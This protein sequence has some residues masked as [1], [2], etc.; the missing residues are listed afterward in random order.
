MKKWFI[1][2]VVLCLL[3]A[4][5]GAAQANEYY[6]L[7]DRMEDFT[8]TLTDG[9]QVSLYG[10]LEEKEAVLINFWATWCGPCQS[11]FPYMQEAYALMSDDI[12]VIALSVEPTDSIEAIE[13]LG[14][15]LGLTT[16]PMGRD[17]N[18]L[19]GRFYFS[20][21]PYSVVVDRNG[22]I[23]Y[24][25]SGAITSA[26]K[27]LRL[28][29]AFTGDDYDEPV[30]LTEI[31]SPTPDVAIPTAAE[32]AAA[33]GLDGEK[34]TLQAHAGPAVWPFVPAAEGAAASN[35]SVKGT[36][37]EF[38]VEVSAEAGEALAFEYASSCELVTEG[39]FIL[40]EAGKAVMTYGGEKDWTE[41]YIPL[42]EGGQLLTFRFEHS[43]WAV[44]DAQ[45]MLR[46][47]RVISA[48]EK[49]EMDAAN[50]P[51]KT[52]QGNEIV[53]EPAAGDVAE[54]WLGTVGT[55]EGRSAA[56][57][58][59]DGGL[60]LRVRI[61]A[62]V[63]EKLVCLYD[64]RTCFMLTDLERDAL[65]YLLQ[66]GQAEGLYQLGVF[67]SALEMTNGQEAAAWINIFLSESGLDSYLSD[68]EAAYLSM[69]GAEVDLEWGYEEEEQAA[70][71]EGMAEYRVLVVDEAGNPIEG[72][73]MQFCDEN[74]CQVVG[75]DAEGIA[76]LVSA[77]YPYE[78]HVLIANGYEPVT[79]NY[80]MP[81]DGGEIR[82]TLKAK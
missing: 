31:P 33:L 76:A 71:P 38:T 9:T 30:L 13:A 52:L 50:P 63:D 46:N 70:L 26:D 37:A 6:R 53:I 25:H 74:T 24:Q 20:G 77:A 81:V 3:L 27:F 15:E 32:L 4:A 34:L 62:D 73:M 5:G 1:A 68:L 75:T 40:D 29:G 2:A 21:I 64:G 59:R 11:E 14:N 8:A 51:V 67:E 66:P 82:V 19:A 69:Y 45:M 61:G 58:V 49:A 23:C 39:L 17:E 7:G 36:Y 28:F 48:E 18:G 57:V 79:K 80:V 55:D 35:G 42:K 41:T 22:V 72:V 43:E 12:G 60:S 47:V 54:V 44:H 56:S 16:L 10:L 65:G 78:V